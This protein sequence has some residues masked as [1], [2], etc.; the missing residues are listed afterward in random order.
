MNPLE[1][2]KAEGTVEEPTYIMLHNN[3]K[4]MGKERTQGTNTLKNQARELQGTNNRYRK[5]FKDA[6]Y[7]NTVLGTCYPS[8]S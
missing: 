4:R 3:L 5:M 2:R 8:A 6:P 1:G 7:K